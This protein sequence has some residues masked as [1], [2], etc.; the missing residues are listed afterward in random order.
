V[1][2]EGP[3]LHFVMK[4]KIRGKRAEALQSTLGFAGCFAVDSDGLSGGIG[5]FWSNAVSAEIKNFSFNHID[6]LV[7]VVDLSSPKWRFTGFYGEPKAENRHHSW[8]FLRTLQSV[9]GRA[10]LCMGDFNETLYG[11][12]HFSQNPRPEWQ[13]RAFREAVEDCSI[14]DLG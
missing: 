11:S 1:R 10:W 5:L 7:Q 9:N 12:E 14:Q 6:A 4:T 3:A 8:R 13:M 2:Q